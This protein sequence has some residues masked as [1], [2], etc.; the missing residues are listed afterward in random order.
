MCKHAVFLM[1]MVAVCSVALA[2]GIDQTQDFMVGLANSAN[3]LV[4]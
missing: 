2:D 4:S 3:L 1:S